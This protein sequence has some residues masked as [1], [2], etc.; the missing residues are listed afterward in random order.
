MVTDCIGKYKSTTIRSWPLSVVRCCWVSDYCLMTN[1]QFFSYIVVRKSYIFGWDHDDVH[2]VS[3][4]HAQ[5][6]I[7]L[8]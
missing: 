7:L 3:A 5:V 4:Q 2:F 1:E 6:G 8:C